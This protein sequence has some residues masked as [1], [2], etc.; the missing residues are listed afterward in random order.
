MHTREI[1][2]VEEP[3]GQS[4]SSLSSFFSTLSLAIVRNLG[5]RNSLVHVRNARERE[6]SKQR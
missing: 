1:T 3:L 4:L 5:K 6:V 2:L